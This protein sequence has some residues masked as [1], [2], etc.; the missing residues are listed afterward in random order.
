VSRFILICIGN[1]IEKVCEYDTYVIGL[2]INIDD[3][4]FNTSGGLVGKTELQGLAL[5]LGNFL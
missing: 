5:I 4:K 1:A 3:I 2:Y